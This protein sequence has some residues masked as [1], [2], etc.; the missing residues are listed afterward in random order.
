MGFLRRLE[1][2]IGCFVSEAGTAVPL[3]LLVCLLVEI[4]LPPHH[5]CLQTPPGPESLT[6]AILLGTP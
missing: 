6:G 4:V 5:F 2:K 3:R 1:Q